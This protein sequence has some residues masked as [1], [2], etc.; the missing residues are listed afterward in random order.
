M[1]LFLAA[2]FCCAAILVVSPVDADVEDGAAALERGE[3]HIANREFKSMADLGDTEAMVRLGLLYS[4]GRGTPR[5]YLEARG[6]YRRAADLGDRR[7]MYLLGTLYGEGKGVTQDYLE[8]LRW[9][10][11]ATAKR[12]LDASRYEGLSPRIA[13]CLPSHLHPTSRAFLEYWYHGAMSTPDF[14]RWFHMPNS[15]Y[16]GVG[17]CVIAVVSGA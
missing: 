12:E 10:V 2:L 11:R 15:S 6:W 14:L 3:L 4:E 7:A 9:Y 16:L 5:D 17:Q 13:A 8:A 1:R